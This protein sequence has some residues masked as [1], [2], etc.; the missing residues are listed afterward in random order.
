M[1]FKQ[2]FDNLTVKHMDVLRIQSLVAY[3]LNHCFWA[4]SMLRNLES[5]RKK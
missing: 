2:V 4:Y 1:G 5:D 3:V